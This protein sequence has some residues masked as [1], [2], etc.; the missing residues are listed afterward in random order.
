MAAFAT[1]AL[2]AA[3]WRGRAAAAAREMA[4]EMARLRARAVT[5][6]RTVG[7]RMLRLADGYAW[8]VC[9]DGDGDG[10]SARDIDTGVDPCGDQRSLRARYEGIDFRLPA[11]AV[12]EL[13][14][15]RGRLAPSGDAVRFGRSDI[16]SFT[17]LGTASSGTLYVG[18]GRDNLFA[19]VLYGHTGRIRTWRFDRQGAGWVM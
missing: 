11:V 2:T 10:L 18:D 17:P 12:P 16:I 1:P 9:L 13:P 5:E 14:P 6:R 7:I 4:M 19:V 8:R 15:G 3:L